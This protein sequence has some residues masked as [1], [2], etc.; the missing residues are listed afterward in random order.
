M[1]D[2][3]IR[4]SG[5]VG[6]I[7]LTRPDALNALTLEMVEA[8][9]ATLPLWAKD[10]DIAML[11]IDAAGEKAFCA[12]GDIA[13][14][15][16]ALVAGDPSV[17][18]DFWRAEYRMNA[19]VFDFPKPVAS[20]MKGYTMGG[21]VGVGCHASHRVVCASS[22]IAMPEVSIGL[23]PD[24][25]GSL[26]LARAPGRVGEY[27]GCT[28]ARMTAG[29]AIFAGFAD[30]FIDE[31][32][33]PDLI[34]TLEETGDWEAI[35]HLAGAAP[36]SDLESQLSDIN[37]FFGGERLRDTL[38]MLRASQSEFAREALKKLA[39]NAPLATCGAMEL[40]HRA[41]VRYRIDEALRGEFRFAYRLA[42]QGDFQEGIRAAIIDRDRAPKWAHA[43]LEDPTAM[44]VASMLFPLGAHELSLEETA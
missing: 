19:T 41:R 35:D 22:Q 14:I 11:V 27:L 21:G 28:G 17:A 1:S 10:D 29:D 24:V 37:E 8:I 42:E 12:G 40:V 20:F 4:K 25:G 32:L 15:Y 5:R 7:T 38:T 9:S 18:R 44:E 30:Y 34:E 39:R 13:D 43:A 6:R 3:D 2:I 33:W 31:P 23:V 26:L 36:T 16:A